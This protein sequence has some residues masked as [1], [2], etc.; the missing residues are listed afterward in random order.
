V[1]AAHA[2]G[3]AGRAQAAQAWAMLSPHVTL[4]GGFTRADD[5][6]VLFSQKL[7]QGRFTP[8]DFAVDRLNQPDPQSALQWG[9]T[10]DQPLWNGGREFAVP[11]LAA[12]Y[13]RA[14]GAAERAAIAD[15]LL[16]AVDAYVAAL[17]AREDARAAEL[18]LLAAQAMRDAAVERF[19][20]GQ[21]PELDTLRVAAR[22]GQARVREIGARRG[23]AVALDRLSRLVQAGVPAESLAPV[24]EVPAVPERPASDRGELTA[25]REGAAAAGTEARTAAL[26]LL[27]SLNSRFAVT[28]YRPYADGTFE[29]RWMVAISA[30]V[31]LFDGGQRWNEWRAAK[32]RATAARA[33]SQMLERDLAVGLAAARAEEAVARERQDAARAGRLAADEAQRLAGE[34]YRAGLLPLTELL[35]TDAEASAARATEVEASAAT[36]LAHYRLLHSQGEL[37]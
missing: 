11:G 34:R 27:P 7:W 9:L 26:R 21:V 10:V 8:A 23:A 15:R 29:R 31:P 14:A 22:L 12:R 17:R 30:D 1:R 18:A 36:I 35:A 3:E 24:D 37:R 13:R 6:A 33:T 28:G 32:A 16:D 20:M 19:R 5:P 4:S 2:N 25:A